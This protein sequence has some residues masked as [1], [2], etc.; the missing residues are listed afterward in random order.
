MRLFPN[1]RA[2][3]ALAHILPVAL[4][5]LL[6]ASCEEE[7]ES[8]GGSMS[9]VPRSSEI[10]SDGGSVWVNVTAS[11]SWI[12]DLEY[13][14]GEG[15][16]ATMDPSSG[17][18]ARS[19]VRMR[20]DANDSEESRSV[21]MVLRSGSRDARA[22][23][24]QAGKGGSSQAQT[25][26]NGYDVAP[27]GWLELPAT[28]SGDGFTFYAHNNSGGKWKP[29]D[30]TR[31]WSMYWSSTEH[32]SVWVAYPLNKKLI[33]NGSRSN[34]WGFDPLIPLDEQPDLT[35][36]S[37]GGGWTRG[38]QIPSADR[39][40]WEQ[41]VSTFYGTNMTPQEYNFNGG[42]W[43]QLEGKVRA[44]AGL[45]DTL[46][47]VTGCQYADS[48]TYTGNS[49]GFYVVVPTHYFKALLYKGHSTYASADGYMAAGFLLPHD[50]SI[51]G[52][53]FLDY[54]MSIDAL[55][56]QTGIDF[57]PSL[58]TL[59]GKDKADAIEAQD[60]SSWWK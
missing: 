25:G 37:Y 42:I 60:P 24:T 21:T 8:D 18:G 2:A 54:I 34:A 26:V 16:W 3:T 11:G 39:L 47:V 13:P 32:I 59:L 17:E 9:I 35:R 10:S 12:I 50:P 19:D 30:G 33:G 43:A 53:N 46:Y 29:G 55:E 1:C 4:S 22:V 56:Q 44:Y 23:V 58:V 5:L 41:N 48:Y 45:S 51:S 36:G 15:G 28:A 38:H 7:G 40:T 27:Y 6:F 20:Y 14:G 52:G 31:N 49:S 57:F